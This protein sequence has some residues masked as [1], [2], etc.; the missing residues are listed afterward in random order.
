MSNLQEIKSTLRS[1]VSMP[2]NQPS[3]KFWKRL[4]FE[5]GDH[6]IEWIIQPYQVGFY[7]AIY[8]S[9]IASSPIQGSFNSAKQ[10]STSQ[11]KLIKKFVDEGYSVSYGTELVGFIEDGLWATKPVVEKV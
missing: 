6:K 4:N 9:M 8:D 5:K 2:K 11:N 3:A 1:L 7:S 10:L